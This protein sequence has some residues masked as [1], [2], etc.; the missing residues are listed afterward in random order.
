[1]LKSF[2]DFKF[3]LLL[4]HYQSHHASRNHPYSVLADGIKNSPCRDNIRVLGMTATIAKRK[5]NR[6]QFLNEMSTLEKKFK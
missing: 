5:C 2:D 1:M 3:L 6:T 4:L